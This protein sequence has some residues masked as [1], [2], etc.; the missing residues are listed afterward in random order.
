VIANNMLV[1]LSIEVR[2]WNATGG[3][4]DCTW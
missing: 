3:I 2:N 1:W 4:L